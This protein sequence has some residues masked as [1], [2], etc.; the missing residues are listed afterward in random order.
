MT[1]QESKKFTGNPFLSFTGILMITSILFLLLMP[2]WMKV[3]KRPWAGY[4]GIGLF[5][6]FYAWQSYYFIISED[7]IIVKNH[8]FFWFNRVFHKDD[9]ASCVITD[10]HKRATALKII[11]KNNSARLYSA[12]SLRDNT[13]KELAICLQEQD[14]KVVNESYTNATTLYDSAKKD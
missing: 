14:I 12:G 6:S 10:P 11:R 2:V 1:Q 5:F 8:F 7:S 13:W 3:V 9:I 4:F